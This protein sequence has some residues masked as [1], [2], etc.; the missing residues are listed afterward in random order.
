[1]TVTKLLFAL[2]FLTFSAGA[3]FGAGPL[4][5]CALSLGEP[6]FSEWEIQS[7]SSEKN[8]HPVFFGELLT[9]DRRKMLFPM[10]NTKIFDA[11]ELG[12]GGR[13]TVFR[14]VPKNG[15]SIFIRKIYKSRAELEIDVAALEIW[16]LLAQRINQNGKTLL[17]VVNVLDV[18]S[19]HIDLENV[20]GAIWDI[21]HLALP[22]F[23]DFL[24]FY[25][26]K[27]TTADLEEVF[28]QLGH[29]WRVANLKVGR[30][31]YVTYLLAKVQDG[32]SRKEVTISN[33]RQN[34][35]RAEDGSIVI[36]DPN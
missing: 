25:L 34:I 11:F 5:Q 36:I 21:D 17:R 32:G 14:L 15:S 2:L 31:G 1:M 29:S 18:K 6:R 9:E 27:I 12:S 28:K 4:G 30:V 35:L 22:K 23:S 13:G 20:R 24:D 16:R 8:D 7:D 10:I 3:S 26:E 19:N 33:W